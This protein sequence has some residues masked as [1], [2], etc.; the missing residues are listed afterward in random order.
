MH[1]RGADRENDDRRRLI[2]QL[3]KNATGGN[4]K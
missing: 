1:D 2:L 3:V 4:L